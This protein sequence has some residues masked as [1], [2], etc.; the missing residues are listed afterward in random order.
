MNDEKM[1]QILELAGR[2]L[3]HETVWGY[4]LRDSKL[5]MVAHRAGSGSS[6][7][8]CKMVAYNSISS[9]RRMICS[10]GG[11]MI[12]V[13]AAHAVANLLAN[14]TTGFQP[15]AEIQDTTVR[16]LTQLEYVWSQMSPE[17]KEKTRLTEER[18]VALTGPAPRPRK[19]GDMLR[20]RFA[21]TSDDWRP[22]KWPPPAPFWNSGGGQGYLWVVA[23]V[24]TFD[25]IKEFWPEAEDISIMQTDVAIEFSDRFEKPDWWPIE[26]TTPA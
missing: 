7:V 14:V 8:N 17:E 2:I 10:N 5:A 18:L 20:V 9:T 21:T 22:V 1:C 11:N 23:Y 3:Q 19:K 15:D 4:L 26:P 12:A 24:K 13:E 6:W 25:Q 16:Y